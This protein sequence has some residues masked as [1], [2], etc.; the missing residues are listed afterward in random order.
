M[1]R[2]SSV[3][4]SPFRQEIEELL[5]SGWSA[6]RIR[7]FLHARDG[8][9]VHLPSSKAIERFRQR[10]I[11]PGAVIPASLIKQA[12]K[13][14]HY[15]VDTLK[16]LDELI[17]AQQQRVAR[18]WDREQQAGKPEPQ[19]DAA[20]RTVL[21]YLRE[22]HR[23]AQELGVERRAG[24]TTRMEVHQSQVLEMPESHLQAIFSLLQR[25][26]EPGVAPSL[27]VREE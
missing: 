3:V 2:P 19:L 23:V 24:G 7:S 26:R 16:L 20:L 4:P 13:G 9:G 25:R 14:L 27:E 17:W 11:P 18:L 22:R 5:K 12:L 1:G 10:H 6:E 15:R 21:E 8:T